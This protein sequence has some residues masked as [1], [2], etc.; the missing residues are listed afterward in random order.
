MSIMGSIT[1]VIPD[2]PTN[3]TPEMASWMKKLDR[4]LIDMFDQ[5]NICLD[6]KEVIG[7]NM[8]STIMELQ[9]D[10]AELKKEIITLK[11]TNG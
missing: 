11:K 10:I 4:N 2:V 9:N 5:V 7:R 6:R 8:E 1:R 3:V